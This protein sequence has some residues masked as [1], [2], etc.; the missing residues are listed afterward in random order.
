MICLSDNDIILKLA[1]CDLLT[2]AWVALG[3][4]QGDVRVLPTAKHKFGLTKNPA[5]AKE[6]YGAEVFAR[7]QSFLSKWLFGKISRKIRG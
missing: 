1:A 5:K 6:R 4:T 7:M 3:L 2:D